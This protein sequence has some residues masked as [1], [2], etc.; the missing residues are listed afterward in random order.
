MKA[1]IL[2]TSLL[3][4]G[5]C[6]DYNSNS[7]DRIKYGPVVLDESDPN[8]ARAYNIISSKCINCHTG[9]HNNWAE[10]KNN[11]AWLDYG[12][13]LRGDPNNS[14]FIQRIIN[15]GGT[16][17]NMPFGGS[18]LSNSDYQHLTKWIEEMP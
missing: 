15:Y 11:D 5:A 18:P 13:L 3:L 4:T 1:I 7:A 14:M 2:L 8:F 17:S 12:I 16:S 6:Q 10:L 9:Y